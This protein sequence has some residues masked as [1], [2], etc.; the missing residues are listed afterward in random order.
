LFSIF[1]NIGFAIVKGMAGLLGNSN[2]LLADAVESAMDVVSSVVVWSGLRI[3]AL[4]PDEDHPWGHGK[5]EPLAGAVVAL[6]LIGA[7]AGIAIK[8]SQ[9]IFRPHSTPA[10]FTLIVLLVVVLVKEGMYRIIAFRARQFHSSS[11]M[12]DAWHHRSDAITS[13]A[14]FIGI[15]IALLGGPAYASADDVA[16]LLACGVIV[17][18]GVGL[19]RPAIA[20]LMDAAPDPE[21]E[22]SVRA[23]LAKVDG[24][25]DVEVCMVRKTG[26][27]F[28]VDLHVHVNGNL[29]VHRGHEIAH[30]AKDRILAEVPH[31]T[32]VLVHVEP[33]L[34]TRQFPGPAHA[35]PANEDK[36]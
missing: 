28:F 32:N 21:T 19:L 15:S 4:P 29:T 14:A 25:D 11:L 8:S 3:A 10:P 33:S 35:Q 9:E 2:A 1:A 17:F 30:C 36:K 7:A 16:A 34:E 5:A 23:V 18:N 12:N 24:I 20:E 31:V 22:K 6:M 27:D 26:L 13:V